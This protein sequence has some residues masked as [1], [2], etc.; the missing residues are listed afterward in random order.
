MQHRC[1]DLRFLRPQLDKKSA[2]QRSEADQVHQYQ[3][4]VGELHGPTLMAEVSQIV[5]VSPPV[6]SVSRAAVVSQAG[7]RCPGRANE[8]TRSVCERE[9]GSGI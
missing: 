2:E 1:V 8:Q 6:S 4:L 9:E 5:E 3:D 7:A